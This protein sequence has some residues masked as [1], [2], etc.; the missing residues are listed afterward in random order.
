M[1]NF[2]IITLKKAGLIGVFLTVGMTA[3]APVDPETQEAILTANPQNTFM[4]KQINVQKLVPTFVVK[5]AQHEDTF[6]DMEK[7]RLLGFIQAQKAEYG[8]VLGVELPSFSDTEN[9]NEARY[10]AI[11]SFLEDQGFHVEPKVIR[12]RLQNS[13]RVY[14]TK[15]VATVDRECAKGWQRPKGLNFE[16]LPLPHMGCSTASGLAQ[17]IAD[18]KDLVEPKNIGGY[19]GE[20]AALSIAKYRSGVSAGGGGGESSEK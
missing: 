1:E 7:G 4:T 15:Y 14:F 17:M 5:F 13:L 11:G 12:D 9:V 6:K 19:D 18:P 8:D 2:N 16:N 20:R 3:C 10:G